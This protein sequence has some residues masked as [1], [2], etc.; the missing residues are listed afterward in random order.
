[1]RRMPTRVHSV[2]HLQHHMEQ[3]ERRTG[4]RSSNGQN[5]ACHRRI[6]YSVLRN[7]SKVQPETTCSRH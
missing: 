1:M 6:Q 7:P 3:L 5:H 4:V 2:V